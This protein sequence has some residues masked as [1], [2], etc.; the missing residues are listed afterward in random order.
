MNIVKKEMTKELKK[1]LDGYTAIK[2]TCNIKF[3]PKVY[4]ENLTEDECPVFDL[5]TLSSVK[6]LNGS[7]ESM[8]GYKVHLFRNAVKKWSDPA[9]ILGVKFDESFIVNDKLTDDAIGMFPPQLIVDIA[10]FINQNSAI[11]EDEEISL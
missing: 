11:S 1:K 7:F 8:G 4:K 2:P 9:G 6:L 10:D 5:V 3:T